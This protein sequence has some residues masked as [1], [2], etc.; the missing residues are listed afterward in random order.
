V[1]SYGT[2]GLIEFDQ[3]AGRK[4]VEITGDIR[5]QEFNSWRTLYNI[6][7]GLTFVLSASRHPPIDHAR[8]RVRL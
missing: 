5:T 3:V 2:P 7:A 6:L 4:E 1:G 8:A